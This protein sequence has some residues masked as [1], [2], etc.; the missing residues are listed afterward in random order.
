MNDHVIDQAADGATGGDPVVLEPE[1]SKNPGTSE[2]PK[3][4]TLESTL[5]SDKSVSTST[6]NAPQNSTSGNQDGQSGVETCPS[7]N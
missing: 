5:I 1:K 2:T 7:G 4:A 6:P 3:G